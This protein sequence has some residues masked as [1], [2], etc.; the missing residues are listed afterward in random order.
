MGYKGS[1]TS[2]VVEKGNLDRN[3]FYNVRTTQ[4]P[5]LTE[6]KS[7][8]S[9]IIPK[10][11]FLGISETPFEHP[12]LFYKNADLIKSYIPTA[13]PSASPTQHA[14]ESPLPPLSL[15]RPSL[16]HQIHSTAGVRTADHPRK[17]HR[18]RQPHH[19]FQSPRRASNPAPFI[20][21]PRRP[22]TAMDIRETAAGSLYSKLR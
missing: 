19:Y 18:L 4:V 17:T 11:E 22:R 9:R 3:E 8:D 14:P 2:I 13:Q 6:V 21:H 10:D 7:A 15:R 5:G 12:Q 20:P 16:P 1:G